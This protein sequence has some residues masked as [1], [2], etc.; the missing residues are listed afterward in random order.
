MTQLTMWET[1]PEMQAWP[2]L[3]FHRAM[4]HA[5]Y[6]AA[7]VAQFNARGVYKAPI[8]VSD[9]RYSLIFLMPD[10]VPPP[11]DEW[12]LAFADAVHNFRVAL[13]SLAWELCNVDGS[14]PADPRA[15][16]FPILKKEEDWT[17]AKSALNSA[18]GQHL[19][20]IR[21]VQPYNDEESTSNT[22]LMLSTLDNHEKHRRTLM[23]RFELASLQ[24]G[25]FALQE[26]AEE[27]ESG[28][29]FHPVE[30]PSPGDAVAE[31]QLPLP[32]CSDSEF[33]P[34]AVLALT[35]FFQDSD[36]NH[37]AIPFLSHAASRVH[38]VI[39]FVIKG[40]VET[41]AGEEGAE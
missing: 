24:F 28:L 26:E 34:H 3:K 19:E 33:P 29:L 22:L 15:V 14:V 1:S 10:G 39:E 32:L 37:E 27:R 17:K 21:S 18:P 6:L 7:R 40:D 11:L 25:G 31:F 30:D 4:E 5:Q 2:Y 36:I 20:R 38:D 16:S 12:A 8:K 13:D 35:P 41:E 23:T 9:D